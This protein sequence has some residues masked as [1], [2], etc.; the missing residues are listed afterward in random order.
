[1]SWDIFIQDL[2]GTAKSVAE[3]PDDFSPAPIGSRAD[4]IGTITSVAPD[5][6]FS[7]PVWG[8]L[9]GPN[10]EYAIEINIGEC[11]PVESITLHVR[12]G[13]AS[14]VQV[15]SIL[16][17]LNLRAIDSSTGDFFDRNFAYSSLADFNAYARQV[18]QG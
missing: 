1:M 17:A 14:V 6:D 10:G 4:L 15:A 11:D 2:P 7:D 13:D 16:A 12:G 9:N 3:I 8:I 18:L 5:A